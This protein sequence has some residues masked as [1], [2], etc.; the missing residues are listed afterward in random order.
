MFELHRELAFARVRLKVDCASEPVVTADGVSA[1]P[2]LPQGMRVD[3]SILYAVELSVDAGEKF[4]I[5]LDVTPAEG[6]EADRESGENLDASVFSQASGDIAA[7]AMR[8]P[9]WFCDTFGLK[10]LDASPASEAPNLS[11]TY[12]AD[13]AS[14]I[15][16]QAAA[17]WIMN[18]ISDDEAFSPSFA[19]DITLNL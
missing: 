9:E 14:K 8:D 3:G 4:S 6:W 13:A 19:V 5:S 7:L 1:M 10:C 18:P 15:T 11:A 16:V 12:K 2:K 17:A